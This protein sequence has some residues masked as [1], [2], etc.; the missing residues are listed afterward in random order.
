MKDNLYRLIPA[1][2]RELIEAGERRERRLAEK[3]L[4]E[5]NERFIALFDRSYD[6]VYIV[7]FEGAFLDA[8]QVALD[9]L[10]Y[11]KSRY[12]LP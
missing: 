4:K 1:I 7:D 9:M 11:D 12:S 2:E 6:A 10:G 8:N 3:Q 5:S